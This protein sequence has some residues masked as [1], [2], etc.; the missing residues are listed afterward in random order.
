[1]IIKEETMVFIKL[2]FD[3]N[4]Y[5][6]IYIITISQ[7]IWIKLNQIN[8]KNILTKVRWQ[9][10]LMTKMIDLINKIAFNLV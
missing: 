3:N 5:N 2:K 9:L 7:Q 8:T 10:Y 4:F 6:K 1:M